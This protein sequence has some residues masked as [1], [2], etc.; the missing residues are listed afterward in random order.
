MKTSSISSSSISSAMQLVVS[1]AQQEIVKLQSESVT[2]TYYDVGLELGSATS[3]SLNFDRESARLQSI[4][5]SNSLAEQR[6]ETLQLSMDQMAASAQSILDTFV[7]VSGSSDGTSA[8]VAA[9]TALAEL[10]SFIGVAQ[11]SVNGEFV[12]S[13]INTD[14]QTLDTDFMD[15]VKQDFNDAL[16]DY[17]AANGMSDA[18]EMTGVQVDEFVADYTANFDW[19]DWTNAS[20]TVMTSR[21]STTETVKTSTSLNGDG[22]KNLVLAA[23]IGS[24]MAGLDL[25]SDA[26]EQVKYNVVEIAGASVSGINAEQSQLGLSQ[27][28]TE[29]ANETLSTQKTIVDTQLSDLTGV[30]QYEANVRLTTLMTQLETSYT[31]TS[32]IQALS[33]VN[34]L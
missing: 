31:I 6:M 7:G 14:A 33:L 18:S 29:T 24:Q 34:Y 28:R 32:K 23:V 21:I 1:S 4:M 16:D 15:D 26:L 12:F 17:L 27:A 10:E 25:Q 11:T 5:D 30:D 3:Q 8:T 2:G 9:N 13:G 22:F 20:D 19:S